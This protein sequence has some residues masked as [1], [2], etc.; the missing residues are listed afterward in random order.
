MA[1]KKQKNSIVKFIPRSTK[2]TIQSSTEANGLTALLLVIIRFADGIQARNEIQQY[3]DN[4]Y[5]IM[6]AGNPGETV[7]NS[8]KLGT[9]YNIYLNNGSKKLIFVKRKS[10]EISAASRIVFDAWIN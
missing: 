3:L 1:Q 9:G 2:K 6:M 4:G 8:S 5:T 7:T 10:R